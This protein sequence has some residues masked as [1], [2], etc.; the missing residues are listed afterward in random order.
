M[1]FLSQTSFLQ[2]GFLLFLFFL[3]FQIW[4][5]IVSPDPKQRLYKAQKKKYLLFSGVILTPACILFIL[6][7]LTDGMQNPFISQMTAELCLPTGAED[8]N[9]LPHPFNSKY[10][11][12]MAGTLMLG[13]HKLGIAL[14][15]HI[16]NVDQK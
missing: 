7:A 1:N 12:I 3:A 16:G 14:S 10:D 4:W 8:L 13:I 15:S 5:P 11:Q 9:L 6:S 2:N